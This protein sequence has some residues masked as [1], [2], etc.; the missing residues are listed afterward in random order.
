MKAW[1]RW[2]M[3]V[4]MMAVAALGAAH[5]AVTVR[6]HP[7][8]TR[9]VGRESLAG[10]RFWGEQGA[11][12]GGLRTVTFTIR[13]EGCDRADLGDFHLWRMPFNCNYAFL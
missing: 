10:L 3:A 5:Q 4:A 12:G 1:A 2:V 7:W 8:L 11:W 9:G 13:Y 6:A